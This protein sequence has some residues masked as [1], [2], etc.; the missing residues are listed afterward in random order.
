MQVDTEAERSAGARSETRIFVFIFSAF[1]LSRL[2]LLTFNDAE[3]TDGYLY[4]Q[5]S[6]DQLELRHPLY[7]LFI[8]AFTPVFDPVVA[9]RFVSSLAG[10]ISLAILYSISL[11][12][13][14]RTAAAITAAL[15]TLS[16]M[17]LWIHSRVLSES[18]FLMFFLAALLYF[19]RTLEEQRWENLFLQIFFSG[20]ATLTRPE[21][22]AFGPLLLYSIFHSTKRGDRKS[23]L[24]TIP[25]F[26]PWALFGLWT[27][28]SGSGYS[29]IMESSMERT[30]VRDFITYLVIYLESYPYVMCYPV[31]ALAFIGLFRSSISKRSQWLFLLGYFHLVWFLTISVHRWWSTRFLIVPLTLLLVEAAGTLDS[32]RGRLQFRSWSI[33][34]AVTLLSCGVL[35]LTSLY[36]QKQVF[37]DVKESAIFVREHFNNHRLFSDEKTKVSYYSR[38]QVHVFQPN[39]S[40]DDGDILILNSFY[41]PL[42]SAIESL[43]KRYNLALLHQSKARTKPI[44]ANINTETSVE[45]HLP[46]KLIWRFQNQRFQS[47]V[48]GIASRKK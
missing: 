23:L 20:L 2:T 35:G 6:F 28:L 11:R 4:I 43:S 39:T 26:I 16:P 8:Q 18:L 3:F 24:Y 5:W 40:F 48:I 15:W 1:I 30:S 38:N 47:L 17:I 34:T 29:N 12:L 36:F 25:A 41:T 44:L 27:L 7:P 22:L 9:G 45:T 42:Q 13:Y 19:L 31:F 37:A 32:L 14:G 21:G 33:L 10:L 46:S